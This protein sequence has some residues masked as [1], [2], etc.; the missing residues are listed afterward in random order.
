MKRNFHPSFP[1]GFEVYSCF[2]EVP[3]FVDGESHEET[4][5]QKKFRKKG[6]NLGKGKS[7]LSWQAEAGHYGWVPR[8]LNM[9][10]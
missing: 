2:W 9:T 7:L 6:L 3:A 8:P 5:L 4:A 10:R 1:H